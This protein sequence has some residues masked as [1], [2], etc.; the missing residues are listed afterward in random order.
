MDTEGMWKYSDMT[1]LSY[2]N[3]IM[4]EP[5]GATNENCIVIVK[6]QWKWYDDACSKR[7]PFICEINVE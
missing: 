2:V 1:A 4:N 5:N 3:F 7:F 6:P